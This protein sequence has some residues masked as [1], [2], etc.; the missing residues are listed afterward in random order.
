MGGLLTLL[1]VAGAA[2]APVAVAAGI[3]LPGVAILETSIAA[4]VALA[5][6]GSLVG[7]QIQEGGTPFSPGSIKLNGK[8]LYNL[9]TNSEILDKSIQKIRNNYASYDLF[10]KEVVP[11]WI[12]LLDTYIPNEHVIYQ[13]LMVII[14]EYWITKFKQGIKLLTKENKIKTKT[15]RV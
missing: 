12:R 6:T 11:Q 4:P 3:T 8:D 13:T 10:T 9:F 1:G 7:G 14:Y 2:L 15:E 5:A